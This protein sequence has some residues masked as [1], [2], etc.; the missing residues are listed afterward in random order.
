MQV[1]AVIFDMDGLM[2]D[3]EPVYQAAWQQAAAELGY[4]LDDELYATLVGRPT[5]ACEAIILERFGAGFP[6]KRFRERWPELWRSEVDRNG[7]QT[8]PGLEEILT[9]VESHRLPVAIATSS[10]TEYVQVTLRRAG[11]TNRFAAMVTGDEISRGKPEPDIYLE[12]ARKLGVP[13]SRCVALEDSEAG[14]RAVQ[15]AGMTGLLVPHWPA[16][17][18]AVQAAYRVVDTLHEARVVL[19]SL[20]GT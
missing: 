2:V 14:I 20:L 8:K 3:T 1:A 18:A 7:V 17:S 5:L 9:F 12:A 16:S 10:E 13:A 19:A 6:L 11:L 4:D 15:A